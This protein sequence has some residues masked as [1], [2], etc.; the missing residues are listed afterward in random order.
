MIRRRLTIET[1]EFAGVHDD[2]VIC[3]NCG[4]EA[5]L[6]IDDINDKLAFFKDDGWRVIEELDCH[7]CKD[8]V[9]EM[10]QWEREHNGRLIA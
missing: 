10:K 9:F 4:D 7:Y 2:F 1:G 8:C 3:D 5:L 6:S